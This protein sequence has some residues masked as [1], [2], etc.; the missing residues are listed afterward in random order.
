MQVCLVFIERVYISLQR[1]GY[2][3]IE[4]GVIMFYRPFA[5]FISG[6]KICFNAY[7]RPFAKQEGHDGPKS[8]T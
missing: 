3:P 2:V 4:V 5:N 7:Y 8:L 6:V 1:D